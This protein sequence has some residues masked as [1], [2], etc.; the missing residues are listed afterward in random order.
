MRGSGVLA[1]GLDSRV[2]Q[3]REYKS[4]AALINGSRWEW[5]PKRPILSLSYMSSRVPTLLCA[6][7]SMDTFNC[8]AFDL[9]LLFEAR[10]RFWQLA[11]GASLSDACGQNLCVWRR[12]LDDPRRIMKRCP[13]SSAKHSW[14]E[15]CRTQGGGPLGGRCWVPT[16]QDEAST[17]PLVMED[18]MLGLQRSCRGLGEA[19]ARGPDGVD[20]ALAVSNESFAR[21]PTCYGKYVGLQHNELQFYGGNGRDGIEF[22]LPAGFLGIATVVVRGPAS[23]TGMAPERLANISTTRECRARRLLSEMRTAYGG[24]GS[25]DGSGSGDDHPSHPRTSTSSSSRGS[26][27]ARALRG[28]EVW[29]Y[30]I[31]ATLPAPRVKTPYRFKSLAHSSRGGG[32]GRLADFAA[33]K[34]PLA[35]FAGMYTDDHWSHWRRVE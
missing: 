12:R 3:P 19:V 31:D 34:L 32:A 13:S 26:P 35:S 10:P 11:C 22:E 18:A 6:Q 8:G 28:A 27:A 25:G 17:A 20:T 7:P 21:Q 15:L 24:G 5:K 4:F 16:G 33:A 1:L 9:V 29:S 14:L 23:H 30:V 2:A